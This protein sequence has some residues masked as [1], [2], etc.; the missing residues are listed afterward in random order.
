M[1]TN[2]TLLISGSSLE[3]WVEWD[4]GTSFADYLEGM[5]GSEWGGGTE[6]AI[7]ARMKEAMA[8]GVFPFKADP[9]LKMIQGSTKHE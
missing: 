3:Q 6:L 5:A 9:I 4:S 2:R 1:S 7:F 8:P